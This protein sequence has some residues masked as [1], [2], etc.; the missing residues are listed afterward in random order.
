[1][2]SKPTPDD[3]RY[4]DTALALAYAHLGKTAPNPSVGCVVVSD[5]KI[6]GAA[7]TAPGGRPHAEPQALQI[8]GD[9]AKGSKVYVTLEPCSHFGQT[10]PCVDALIAAQPGE[11]II[12]CTDPYEKVAGRGIKKL[13][14][15]GIP[16]REGVRQSEA[17]HLNAG[18]FS[19]IMHGQPAVYVDDRSGLYDGPL[20]MKAGQ[21][22]ED[23]IKA[24]GAKGQTRIFETPKAT[25][26]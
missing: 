2:T 5:G 7:A 23:A 22:R 3:L 14:S 24:A 6:V 12:A 21:S 18:F 9:R 13:K 16:V 17:E 4:M 11:V 10:P 26:R 19:Y 1:M 20:E 25:S 8:A 15:A